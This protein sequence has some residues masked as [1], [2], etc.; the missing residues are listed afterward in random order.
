VFLDD[1][2]DN[3]DAARALD[4]RSVLVGAD[5][6]AALQELDAVLAS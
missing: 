3:V 1:H 6:E 5:I 4:I 2:Q